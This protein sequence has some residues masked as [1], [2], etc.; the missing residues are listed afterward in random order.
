VIEETDSLSDSEYLSQS[1]E[2]S[3]FQ[4]NLHK[5]IEESIEQ[6]RKYSLNKKGESSKRSK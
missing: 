6:A 3:T 2:D 1:S 4:D 5:A